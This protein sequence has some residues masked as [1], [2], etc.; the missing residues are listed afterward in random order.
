MK[1]FVTAGLAVGFLPTV[2]IAEEL[3]AGTIQIVPTPSIRF[4]RNLALL[5]LKDKTLTKA[6]KAFLE[7]AIGG[8][9]NA[10]LD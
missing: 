9:R 10:S 7:I 5:Y 8:V 1:R 2:M 6:A 3:K 4:S